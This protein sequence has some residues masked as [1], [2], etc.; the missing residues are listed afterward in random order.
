M[1]AVRTS[2]T[3]IPT[4]LSDALP[5]GVVLIVPDRFAGETE[6][7]WLRRSHMIRDVGAG[8]REPIEGEAR[9]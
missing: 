4:V 3:K 2:P 7:R 6:E 9:C 1:P 5:R 8:T